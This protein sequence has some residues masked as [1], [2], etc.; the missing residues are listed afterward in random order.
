MSEATFPAD[1]QTTLRKLAPNIIK[2]E[3]Y[4]DFLR[5]RTFRQTLLCHREVSLNR[6][7]S[8]ESLSR[9]Y[10][11]CPAKPASAESNLAAGASEQFKHPRG[12][13]LT[14]SDA[15]VKAA[16]VH[17]AE[18]WPEAVAFESLCASARR[19]LDPTPVFDAATV[20]NDRRV[21][22]TRLLQTYANNFVQLHVHPP[23]VS[24]TP[25]NKPAAS[26]LARFQASRTGLVTNLCH[27]PVKLTEFNRHLVCQLDGSRDQGALVDSLADLVHQN[28]LVVRDDQGDPITDRARTVSILKLAVDNN[29]PQLA[30]QALLVA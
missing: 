29:L 11:A 30:Q 2:M 27:E 23:A 16:L 28:V 24:S 18:T 26:S 8:H 7:L 4:M 22:G 1:V 10:V 6:R 17:L 13:T 20:E 9:L 3:Q 25:G 5:N 12:I 15:L 19:R 21:L 14:S